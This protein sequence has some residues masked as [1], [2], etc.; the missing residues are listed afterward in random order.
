[1]RYTIN[2]EQK[3]RERLHK[4][5]QETEAAG[6]T[7]GNNYTNVECVCILNHFIFV[8][9]SAQAREEGSRLKM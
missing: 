4:G 7:H 6:S 8:L 5:R 2:T 3:Q 9:T 1:M